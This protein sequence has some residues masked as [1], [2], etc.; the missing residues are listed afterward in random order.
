MGGRAC[1]GGRRGRRRRR[2]GRARRPGHGQQ[3]H[4]QGGRP[5]GPSSVSRGVM[6]HR[7]TVARDGRLRPGTPAGAVAPGC[8]STIRQAPGA[9]RHRPQRGRDDPDPAADRPRD[10]PQGHPPA[11][12]RRGRGHGHRRGAP[13]ALR[14]PCRQGLTR[15]GRGAGRAAPGA[16]RGGDRHHADPTGRGQDDHHHRARPGHG[17]HRQA[18]H[19]R[20]PPVL[21]G[22]DVRDQGRGCRRRLQPGGAVRGV[23]PP[24]DRRHARRDRRPQHPV[25]R[26]RQPPPPRQRAP[27]STSTRS[28]GDG[29]STSTTVRCA[30]WSSGSG[31]PRTGCPVSPDS[32]SPPPPRSWPSWRCRRRWPTCAGGWAPSSSGSTPTAVR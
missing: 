20:H 12:R 7:P 9:A 15:R 31:R 29:C 16:L 10:R 1:P 23:Q 13:P 22:P 21:D 6:S 27:I 25:G 11:H 30:T 28:R 8:R 18:G 4:G 26:R 14:P 2:R 32:T 3:G 17:P 5:A 24:P 19:R